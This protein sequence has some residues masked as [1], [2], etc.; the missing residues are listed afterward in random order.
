MGSGE[1]M[2][3]LFVRVTCVCVFLVVDMLK[4]V[5]IVVIH[6]CVG[7]LHSHLV[8]LFV[9]VSRMCLHGCGHMLEV[10]EVVVTHVCVSQ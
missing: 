6:V 5:E 4:V 2:L 9:H 7:Q 8:R 1:I 3:K 10:V